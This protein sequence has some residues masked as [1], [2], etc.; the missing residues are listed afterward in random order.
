MWL[1]SKELSG[2]C[3]EKHQ[4]LI[5]MGTRWLD[6]SPTDCTQ[7]SPLSSQETLCSQVQVQLIKMRVIPLVTRKQVHNP[8]Q[9]TVESKVMIS[10]LNR[11]TCIKSVIRFLAMT[12][13]HVVS[14]LFNS[15]FFLISVKNSHWADG[16]ASIAL[17]ILV[18]IHFPSSLFGR[19]PLW[20]GDCGHCAHR[21]AVPS[22]GKKIF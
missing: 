14:I 19:W 21:R 15:F 7:T 4:L 17:W 10:I 2:V 1:N 16:T 18:N 8:G 3:P 11:F 20:P 9:N 5:L 13:T 12:C 22:L 6:L